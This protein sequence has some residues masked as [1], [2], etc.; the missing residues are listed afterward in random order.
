MHT[1][2]LFPFVPFALCTPSKFFVGF[3]VRLLAVGVCKITMLV[4][5]CKNVRIGTNII[6]QKLNLQGINRCFEGLN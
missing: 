5:P 2:A 3:I 6:V 4:T 1:V